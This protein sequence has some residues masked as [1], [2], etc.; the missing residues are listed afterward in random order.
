MAFSLLFCWQKTKTNT[1][2]ETHKCWF[3]PCLQGFWDNVRPLLP[4][5]RFFLFLFKVEISSRTLIPLYTPGSVH[6]GPTSW[7]N[8]WPCAPWRVACELVSWEVT[9]LGPDSG[10]VS[11]LR[12]RWVKGVCVF[13]C[14]LPLELLAECPGSFKCQCGNTLV[15]RTPNKSQHTS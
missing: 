1:I 4:C 11:P 10:K 14:N 6:S 2:V 15:K 3:F 8:M 5:L 13:R 7:D 9:S 12:L